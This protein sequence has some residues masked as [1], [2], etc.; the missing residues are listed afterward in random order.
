MSKA[1]FDPFPKA[2]QDIVMA[3]GAELEAFGK[4]AAVVDDIKVADVY[5]KAGTKVYDLDLSTIR[6]SSRP[7]AAPPAPS[8]WRSA[9]R[10]RRWSRGNRSAS[11]AGARSS[12]SGRP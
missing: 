2:Q 7:S 3:G 8:T 12:R 11:P 9:R 4:A 6:Y 1:I 5:E 10:G